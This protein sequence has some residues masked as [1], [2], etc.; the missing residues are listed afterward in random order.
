MKAKRLRLTLPTYFR[1]RWLGLA[2]IFAVLT[3]CIYGLAPRRITEVVTVDGGAR[4]ERGVAPMRRQVVWQPAEPA[5]PPG[6][7]VGAADSLI[8]PALTDDG[9]VLYF[10]LRKRG[11][12]A[13]IFRSELVDGKWQP[14]EPVVALNTDADDIGPVIRKDGRQ[15]Y[16][17]SNREGG[18]GGFD[19]YVSHRT[20]DGWSP[21]HN[22]GLSVNSPAHEYDPAITTDGRKLFFASNRTAR[23][24]KLLLEGA[25]GDKDDQWQTTLRADLGLNKFDLYVASRDSAEEG[26]WAQATSL[27]ELNTPAWNEGAP[28][29]SNDGAFLYFATDRPSA[30]DD[31]PN[32]DIYRSRIRGTEAEPPE[33][34]GP[35]INTAANEIEPALSPEGFRLYFSRNQRFA[36]ADPKLREQYSLFA[37]T[38]VEI[39]EIPRWD[40]ANLMSLL[41]FLADNWWW[42]VLALL[43]LALL[44]A[45]AALL[46]RITIRRAQ[47]P[48]YLLLALLI[49]LL[50]G[51]GSFW[52]FL[53]DDLVRAISK[54]TAGDDVIEAEM[55]LEDA[56][57]SRQP[58]PQPYEKVADVDV[59]T[60]QP[61]PT[62]RQ[63]TVA[64]NVPVPSDTPTVKVPARLSPDKT[65]RITATIPRAEP[66][67]TEESPDLKPS[68]RVLPT[69]EEERVPLENVAQV[70]PDRNE[71]QPESAEVAISK[72]QPAPASDA[73]TPRASDAQPAPRLLAENAPARRSST[74]PTPQQAAPQERLARVN[75]S[76]VADDPAESA[77]TVEVPVNEGSTIP[78]SPRAVAVTAEQRRST[79]QPDIS[80]N[81]PA[82]NHQVKA[83]PD[84]DPGLERSDRA[85]SDHTPLVESSTEVDVEL[86]AT[87]PALGAP[88][89]SDDQIAMAEGRVAPIQVA[90]I[91]HEPSESDARLTGFTVGVELV[92]TKPS[93][94]SVPTPPGVIGGPRDPAR[95]DLALGGLSRHRIDA[96]LSFG[97]ETSLLELPAARAPRVLYGQDRVNLQQLLRRRKMSDADK[98]AIIKKYGG[99]DETLKSIRLGLD[100]M[101]R[102]QMPD[103]R[104]SLT[105][106]ADRYNNNDCRK[107]DI[108]G[109]GVKCDTAATGFALLSFLGENS[110]HFKGQYSPQVRRGLDWLLKKQKSDGDLYTGGDGNSHMYSHGIATIAL[111]ECY[112][113]TKDPDL[114]EPAQRALDFIVAAQGGHGGWRY[115][116]RDNNS[117]TSVF[118]WQIMALKSGQIAGL[119]VPQPT[120]EKAATWLKTVEGDGKQDGQ[121]R[122]QRNRNF[123]E[124]MTAEGLLCLAYFGAERGDP[125]LQAGAKFLREHLPREGK[126]SSYYWYYGTQVMYHV[127]GEPWEQWNGALDPMLKQTQINEG[128]MAGSWKPRDKWETSGGRVM[129]TSLRILML[130]ISY[131]YLPL[132]DIVQ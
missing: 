128:P 40:A 125:Q 68:E 112:G 15:L 44:A 26:T 39:E 36:S 47:I 51:G 121:Y 54:F 50:L 16:L 96:P 49:H 24:Q 107:W 55:V 113:M 35:G 106:W 130:E 60:V 34:L 74:R 8:R 10:T 85:T 122:Y 120:L 76:K 3:A 114:R 62:P 129:A 9:T 94:F 70:T 90:A 110:T 81:L 20:A 21:P 64:P 104:W 31:D 53:G 19:I 73:P 127:Q 14:A 98:L 132:Y 41:A 4:W 95:T 118:G 109:D 38:A 48:G 27:A 29:V 33:S 78:A 66:T 88:P 25:L 131:R 84:T 56:N 69:V 89:M 12:D 93:E 17:Y 52:V 37:S 117:D 63:Q 5:D 61:S 77:A 126:G 46:Q 23:M 86:P 58:G 92:R 80:H 1:S 43:L 119:Y 22:L 111:C 97:P 2:V 101:S 91:G 100:W 42:I 67:P 108:K 59:D 82:V 87:R 102:H 71:T 7:D 30:T 45:L 75:P 123:E 105:E 79:A 65:D 116:P 103:G 57:Q 115:R 72:R 99:D 28:F 32:F 18:Y 83:T 13:N 124:A 11:T 6:K